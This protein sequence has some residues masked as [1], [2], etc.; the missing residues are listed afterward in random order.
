MKSDLLTLSLT[1]AFIMNVRVTR[2]V[3]E[4]LCFGVGDSE[5]TH[6]FGVKS[7]NHKLQRVARHVLTEYFHGSGF[8]RSVSQTPQNF[9]V[10]ND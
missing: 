10:Q 4:L 2:T 5:N 9:V 6:K 7:T 8:K 1:S 3:S